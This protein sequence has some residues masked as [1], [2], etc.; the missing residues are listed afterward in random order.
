[1]QLELDSNWTER[2]W[3]RRFCDRSLTLLRLWTNVEVRAERI[4][5]SPSAG[6]WAAVVRLGAT[7]PSSFSAIDALLPPDHVTC[8]TIAD[9][10]EVFERIAPVPDIAIRHLLYEVNVEQAVLVIS[11]GLEGLH[12]ACHEAS[13]PFPRI[14]NKNA[15]VVA[16]AAANAALNK[17][18]DE[19]WVAAVE[20]Q[21]SLERLEESFR[22]FNQLTFAERLD[23]LLQDVEVVAPGLIGRDR[24][25]WI[26]EVVAARNVEAHRLPRKGESYEKR[27]DD[28][29]Q[30]A[31]SAEWV[32][33]ISL[34]LHLGVEPDRLRRRLYEHRRF[35]FALANMDRC[36]FR[37]P[38]SRLDEFRSSE[39]EKAPP[40]S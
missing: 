9:A 34:L 14:S 5:L 18:V 10:L 25:L 32:L 27:L 30:L 11:S 12:R 1:M 29:Y 37:W 8:R 16:A 36:S 15:G 22:Y 23:Q 38:G 3:R 21:E 6:T 35:E 19:G 17:A 7:E 28:Y 39:A 26:S 13:K 2:E 20:R 4:E 24:N 40:E 31:V 33:R